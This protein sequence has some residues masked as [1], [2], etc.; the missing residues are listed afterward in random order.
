[1][2]ESK[3][4]NK[5]IYKAL[6]IAQGK[7][8]AASKSSN[9]PFFKS[10]YADLAEVISVM[11]G[12]AS[13]NGLA[14]FFD[15]K[16]E[17]SDEFI[18]YILSH[19]SGECINSNWVRMYSKDKTAQGFGSACTYYKRQLLK[20]VFNIPE[21]DDDG[22]HISGNSTVKPQAPAPQPQPAKPVNYAPTTS[23]GISEAQ[24]NQ[25]KDLAK[26]LNMTWTTLMSSV[27]SRYSVD[28]LELLK[29]DQF[30]DLTSLLK[31]MLGK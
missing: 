22:N 26:K 29:K 24:V 27:K 8:E 5:N 11:Q 10:K 17:G 4:P 14:I 21:S 23:S 2:E 28:K 15:F 16:S 30:D 1:M 6:S 3:A 7:I 19:D 13:E 12:P 31:D 25:V 20:A 18:K 9:N